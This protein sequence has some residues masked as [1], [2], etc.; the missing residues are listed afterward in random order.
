MTS[1]RSS[2]CRR[3]PDNFGSSSPWTDDLILRSAA[4][5]YKTSKSDCPPTKNVGHMRYHARNACGMSRHALGSIIKS[6]P[7]LAQSLGN[8]C[9]EQVRLFRSPQKA[10][11]EE[12]RLAGLSCTPRIGGQTK[13]GSESSRMQTLSRRLWS[14]AACIAVLGALHNV[15]EAVD[16]DVVWTGMARASGLPENDL[17]IR[18]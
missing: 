2:R 18:E 3:N 15:A 6:R 11:C 14:F 16:Q 4:V 12:T 9:Q 10:S 7:L 8:C 5:K 1:W 17:S 13:V